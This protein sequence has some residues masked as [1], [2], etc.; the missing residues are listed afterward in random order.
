MVGVRWIQNPAFQAETRRRADSFPECSSAKRAPALTIPARSFVR[1]PINTPS[2]SDIPSRIAERGEA[3]SAGA[4]RTCRT[5]G[6]ETTEAVLVWDAATTGSAFEGASITTA[7]HPKRLRG[8][9]L[10]YIKAS[11]F[12]NAHTTD[13]FVLPSRYRSLATSHPRAHPTYR[14]ET[15]PLSRLAPHTSLTLALSRASTTKAQT[16]SFGAPPRMHRLATQLFRSPPHPDRTDERGPQSRMASVPPP[17]PRHPRTRRPSGPLSTAPQS[18]PTVAASATTCSASPR[19]R[20][21][22]GR[23]PR[24]LRG[25]GIRSASGRSAIMA[26][27]RRVT[28]IATFLQPPPRPPVPRVRVML[29]DGG[30]RRNGWLTSVGR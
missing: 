12:A 3:V 4:E 21:I 17:K 2:L 18:K 25:A 9:R 11:R 24:T 27:R 8:E 7:F 16:A 29:R 30:L 28:S 22:N 20:S 14:W 13:L 5:S 23:A 26:R 1:F 6:A 10:G 15:P 19:R